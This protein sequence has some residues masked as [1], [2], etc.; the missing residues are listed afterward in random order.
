MNIETYDAES[1]RKLVRLLEYE[2]R[3]LKEKL[4][5]ENIPYDEVNPFEETIDNVEEYDQGERIV[6]KYMLNDGIHEAIVSEELWNQVH[7]KRQE[8]G[9][10][11][12]KTHSLDHEHILSG[13]IKCP[14]CGS[15]MYGNVNRKKHPDGGYY[16]DYFYYA[17]KHRTFVNGHKCTYR[18]QWSED[19]INAA[20]E[21]VI[22]KLVN[23][24]KFKTES[25]Q[26]YRS[27]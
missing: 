8:T 7:K 14:I 23:N 15:G 6:N 26:V 25:I 10:A 27:D 24:P 3:L 9:V 21:E 19:K 18:K 1:L 4:K 5:K 22:R 17:C 12:I 11:N 16:R 2:N 20:V 13:I